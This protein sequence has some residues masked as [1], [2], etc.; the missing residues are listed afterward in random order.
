MFRGVTSLIYACFLCTV[1]YRI[2]RRIHC[3]LNGLCIRSNRLWI[4]KTTAKLLFQYAPGYGPPLVLWQTDARPF[5]SMRLVYY[6]PEYVDYISR[7]MRRAL[8]KNTINTLD[9]LHV[10]VS[11]VNGDNH[12]F[13][14]VSG[15]CP[16]TGEVRAIVN[17]VVDTFNSLPDTFCDKAAVC[18]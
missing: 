8:D 9:R 7:A 17:R 12:R 4:F 15:P 16:Y 1:A 18:A 10:R 13:D 2:R 14:T 6:H 11:I 5:K 3:R